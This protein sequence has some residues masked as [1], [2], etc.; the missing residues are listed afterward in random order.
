[1]YRFYIQQTIDKTYSFPN[2]KSP[3]FFVFTRGEFVVCAGK[4]SPRIGRE[5]GGRNKLFHSP[6]SR[7]VFLIRV[8]KGVNFVKRTWWKFATAGRFFYKYQSRRDPPP[9]ET[10]KY[11]SLLFFPNEGT[12]FPTIFPQKMCT[13]SSLL[14]QRTYTYTHFVRNYLIADPTASAKLL[15]HGI[16]VDTCLL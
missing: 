2:S 3:R 11:P 10:L 13:D 15:W 12:S 9:F 1:M 5:R 14:V 7:K 4:R 16:L 8:E 6:R